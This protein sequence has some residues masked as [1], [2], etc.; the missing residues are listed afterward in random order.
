MGSREDPGLLAELQPS[1]VE[2]SPSE[3]VVQAPLQPRGREGPSGE[4]KA[5]QGLK[6]FLSTTCRNGG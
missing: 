4:A 3:W 1:M 5:E 6:T 2:M